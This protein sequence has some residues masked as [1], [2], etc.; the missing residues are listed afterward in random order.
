MKPFG[1][2]PINSTI[3]LLVLFIA[4]LHH[5]SS[6]SCSGSLGDMI[7]FRGTSRRCVDCSLFLPI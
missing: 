1:K 4:V 5:P 3:R 7:L 2:P 6:S